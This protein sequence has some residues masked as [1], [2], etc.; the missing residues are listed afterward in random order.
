MKRII[1]VLLA[2]VL[3]LLPLSVAA[4]ATATDAQT[5]PSGGVV[6]PESLFRDGETVVLRSVADVATY[7]LRRPS[8]EGE[9]HISPALLTTEEGEEEVYFVAVYGATGTLK[10]ANN[11]IACFLCAFNLSSRYYEMVRDAVLA[12]VPEGAKVV[13]AGHSLGGMVE[14][15]LICTEA[16]T[17]RYEVL[18]ALNVGSPYVATDASKREGTLVR[19]ADRHDVIPKLG[20]GVFLPGGKTGL[21]VEDGGYLGDPDGAHNLSYRRGD[22]FGAYDALG[23]LNGGAT[24]TVSLPEVVNLVA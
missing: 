4:Y 20:P 1:S 2:A 11:V 14:Q 5:A 16:I 12:H 8:G 13:F 7:I 23:V 9:I 22:L 3:L 10:K 15:Q 18:N 19:F 6:E 24:L 21:T 17:S